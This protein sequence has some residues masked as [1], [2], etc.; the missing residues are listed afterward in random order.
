MSIPIT[1]HHILVLAE[2]LQYMEDSTQILT[3]LH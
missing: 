3:D 1:S 2:E